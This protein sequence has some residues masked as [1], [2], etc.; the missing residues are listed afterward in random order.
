ML[1]A[2]IA[3]AQ[4]VALEG[5]DLTLAFSSTAQFLRR[6]AEEPANRAIVGEALRT[7]SPGRW[8]LAYE[9]RDVPSSAGE[10]AEEELSEDELVRRFIEEF[11]AEEV[12]P[13]WLPEGHDAQGDADALTAERSK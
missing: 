2:L 3:E 5:F 7:L 10:D 6:K 8:R 12:P 1:G 9:L 11:D 13:D 4:P